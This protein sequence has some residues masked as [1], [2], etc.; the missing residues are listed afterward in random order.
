[1]TESISYLPEHK[2][3]EIRIITEI[4]KEVVNPEMIILF[5]S[6]AK[7]SYVEHRYVSKGIK[8]E[9]ISDYDFLVVTKNNPEKAY[10]QESAI[11]SK[12]EMFEPPVNLEIHEID[13]IN[14]GLEWGEYF[15]ID[16]VEEG[17]L[18]YDKGT[19]QFSEPRELTSAEKKEKAQR[20]F[21]TWFPQANEFVEGAKFHQQRGSLKIATFNLHQ[22][23]E[24]L[25]YATLLVFTDYKP[26]THNLWKLR[27]KA[28]PYSEELFHVFRAETD[29]REKDLFELLKQGYVDA[30][31]RED[32]TITA[33]EVSILIERV[34][35]MIPIVEKL[36]RE[37]ISS[38]D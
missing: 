23:T 27:R 37:K 19:V 38:I 26:K 14:K 6:Y 2:Q 12:A 1:M 35:A 36:C 9:Y 29:K 22:A 34:S 18:M 3:H 20:Y 15:W 32:F 10:V 28:K 25:Y 21:D 31:Y 4:I 11:A 17:I 8:F 7:N 33:E 30:R 13:Y 24:S 16:I 5:G